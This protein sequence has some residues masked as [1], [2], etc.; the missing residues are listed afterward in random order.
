MVASWLGWGGLKEEGKD[1]FVFVLMP[2]DLIKKAFNWHRGRK[3]KLWKTGGTS[4]C[5][6]DRKEA[7][8]LRPRDSKCHW[9]WGALWCLLG[10]RTTPGAEGRD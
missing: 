7:C 5:R 9:G 1:E 4:S 8:S 2:S 3:K 10:T 6:G